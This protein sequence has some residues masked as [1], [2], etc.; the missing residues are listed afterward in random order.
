MLYIAI[1]IFVVTCASA[2]FVIKRRNAVRY[3]DYDAPEADEV[4]SDV[5]VV[6]APPRD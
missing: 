6:T 1:A 2:V 5:T 4:A 3:V